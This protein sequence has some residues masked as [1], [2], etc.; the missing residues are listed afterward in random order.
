LSQVIK[1][2]P[3]ITWRAWG[4]SKQP[5]F[6]IFPGAGTGII[7]VVP[8]PFYH[9]AVAS[10]LLVHPGLSNNIS[11][12][13]KGQ[14]CAFLYGNT[15]PD[16]QVISGQPR[17]TT[18]FFKLPIE[19]N[20]PPAWEAFMLAYPSVAD[21]DQL[22]PA[23]AAFIA[24][25]LCHLLAD[26]LWIRDIYAPVFGPSCLWDTFT[27]RLYLHNVLR[28]ALDRMILPGLPDDIG[29]CLDSITPEGWLPF[30]EDVHL[31]KWRDTIA[32][33][34]QPGGNSLTVEVFARR[35]GVTPEEFFS[36]LNSPERMESEVYSQVSLQK[37]AAYRQQIRIRSLK[38]LHTYLSRRMLRPSRW[39][40][41]PMR[42]SPPL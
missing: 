38:V 1:K 42:L 40:Y 31:C 26:W 13:L 12:F 18:H 22:H 25:Y 15:A 24:G 28:A 33:Q 36:L 9:L 37:L 16:V 6:L 39:M 14:R 5:G 17:E 3:G 27:H 7:S 4:S 30:V 11:G 2:A 29:A 41:P 19:G 23:Q 34:L 20:A 35:Q 10:E 21:P 32:G 8:T